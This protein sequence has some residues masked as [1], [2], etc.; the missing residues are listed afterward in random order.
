MKKVE[1]QLS[2]GDLE[3]DGTEAT[4]DERIPLGDSDG[5][6]TVLSRSRRKKQR[7]EADLDGQGEKA[8][9]DDPPLP[10]PFRLMCWT[11]WTLVCFVRTFLEVSLRNSLKARCTIWRPIFFRPLRVR[12]LI[13]ELWMRRRGERLSNAFRNKGNGPGEGGLSRTPA[14]KVKVK[15]KKSSNSLLFPD[16]RKKSCFNFHSPSSG[17]TD[18]NFC[19]LP[20]PAL[21]NLKA[22]AFSAVCKERSDVDVSVGLV[23]QPCA[24]CGMG[25]DMRL[26]RSGGGAA[27]TDL[28]GAV[29]AAETDFNGAL[30]A[31]E[32]DLNGAVCAVETDFHGIIPRSRSLSQLRGDAGVVA[33]EVCFSQDRGQVADPV[34]RDVSVLAELEGVCVRRR[35]AFCSACVDSDISRIQVGSG[36]NSRIHGSQSSSF[37]CARVSS[38]CMP[39]ACGVGSASAA[40]GSACLPPVRTRSCAGVAASACGGMAVEQR[41]ACNSVVSGG[42]LP[43][44]KSA[45]YN[46][47]TGRQGL[48]WRRCTKGGV[49][50]PAEDLLPVSE[51]EAGVN[52]RPAGGV[53]GQVA[54]SLPRKQPGTGT[55]RQRVGV[56]TPS[57]H[58][59]VPGNQFVSLGYGLDIRQSMGWTKVCETA[60]SGI[61]VL[62][63]NA[64]T[65]MFPAIGWNG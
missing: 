44:Q 22:T 2:Q 16:M 61:W 57:L 40:V 46:L 20:V 26:L 32:T 21:S 6:L 60:Q 38:G 39:G 13:V 14:G 18:F 41:H 5:F 15:S 45:S 1:K 17:S 23:G 63:G 25:P 55:R 11:G 30:G 43:V 62:K 35:K 34:A 42:F 8:P 4:D 64:R 27:E 53:R 9:D 47:G 36:R 49:S 65:R 19:I 58:P 50:G 3:S 48:M 33:G 28:N 29:C 54:G 10:L 59:E 51:V 7:R 12:P 37:A 24:G 31:A 56:D 52:V